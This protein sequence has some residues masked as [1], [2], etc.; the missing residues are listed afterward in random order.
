MPGDITKLAVRGFQIIFAAVVTGLSIDL[1]KGHHWGGLPV[2]LGYVSFVGCISLLAGFAGV[3]AVFV[4]SLQGHIEML[5]D[6]FIMLLNLAGG[7]LVAVKLKGV[8]CKDGDD[9]PNGLNILTNDLINGGKHGDD[10]YWCSFDHDPKLPSKLISRCKMNQADDA[11]MFLTVVV[12]L[13]SL[14]LTFLRM[15]K[16]Y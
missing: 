7:V 4:S 8:E 6:G 10:C 16:G 5:M 11:F 2:T 12:L 13:V 3:A 1:A 15:K 9:Q 14:T